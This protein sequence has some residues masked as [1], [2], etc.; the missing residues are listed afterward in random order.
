MQGRASLLQQILSSITEV[1]QSFLLRNYLI[2]LIVSLIAKP[3]ASPW[4]H[5]V[6]IDKKLVCPWLG[7]TPLTMLVMTIILQLPGQISAV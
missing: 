7:K 5:P 6:I 4:V 2:P 1:L 3:S